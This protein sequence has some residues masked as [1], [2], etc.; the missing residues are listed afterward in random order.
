[1]ASDGLSSLQETCSQCMG[2]HLNALSR[3]LVLAT[4]PELPDPV[5]MIAAQVPVKDQIRCFV[6]TILAAP[7]LLSTLR[8]L[9]T[10]IHDSKYNALDTLIE[11][12]CRVWTRHSHRTARAAMANETVGMEGRQCTQ[13]LGQSW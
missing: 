7:C 10:A 6:V 9:H 3:I 11:L 8:S 4:L 5:M 12:A 2:A 1:M 13:Y